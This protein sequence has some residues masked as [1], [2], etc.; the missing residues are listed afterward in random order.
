MPSRYA[1]MTVQ[2]TRRRFLLIT[3]AACLA[4]RG[5]V[6]ATPGLTWRGRAFGADA[7]VRLPD[8]PGAAVALAAVAAEI[9]R[10]E[11]IFSLYQDGS[12]IR[13]LNAAGVLADPDPLLVTVLRLSD[14]VHAE[15]DGAFDPTVQPIWAAHAAAAGS[16]RT[17]GHAAIGA[18]KQRTGWAN[19][20]VSDERIAFAR[21]GMAI[22][23]NGI[24]QGFAADRIAALL[25]RRGFADVLVDTGEVA[26][27]GTDPQDRPWPV[28]IANRDGLPIRRVTLSDRALATSAP[29]ATVLDPGG[30]VGHI[31]DPRTGRPGGRWRTVS[32]SAPTAA[33]AD[34]L[35]TAFCILDRTRIAAALAAFP[36]AR[37]EV[38][39]T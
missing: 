7:T 5:V 12:Q 25:R 32:V 11:R 39:E 8:R 26:A 17:P 20:S 10:L 30:T 13:R 1:R 22:T 19:L 4:G 27:H 15:T 9:D 16:G 6:A 31:L 18:L 23:L 33:L 28:D 35:S 24:A 29:L 21:P 14:Q 2:P 37:V 3:T 38:L 34:A 36:D